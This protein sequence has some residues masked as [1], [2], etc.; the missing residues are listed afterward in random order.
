MNDQTAIIL[1]R[2]ETGFRTDAVRLKELGK[3]FLLTL[4]SARRISLHDTTG[5][6]QTDWNRHWDEVERFL[7]RIS[8]QLIE[9]EGHLEHDDKEKL[10]H[11]LEAWETIQPDETG[12]EA[13]LAAVRL[14][15]LPN[16]AARRSGTGIPSTSSYAPTW[17]RSRPQPR[18]CG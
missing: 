2:L 13:A 12:L 7:H 18:L 11:S 8:E 17:T 10:M 6:W 5:R 16:W 3:D 1:H 15:E 4:E 9:I 14:Q